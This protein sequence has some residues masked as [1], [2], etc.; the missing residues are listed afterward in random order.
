MQ[1]CEYQKIQNYEYQNI[2][3]ECTA[4][5]GPVNPN[6]NYDLLPDRF[7]SCYVLDYTL[8][9]PCGL[10]LVWPY[11]GKKLI[12]NAVLLT[13]SNEQLPLPKQTSN[14]SLKIAGREPEVLY[15]NLIIN[16]MIPF[17]SEVHISKFVIFNVNKPCQLF[18]CIQT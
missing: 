15:S 3:I 1:N 13:T 11:T 7:P 10:P 2:N 9:A 5:H 6:G 8:K 4:R 14:F 12:L 18:G 16:K 17:F